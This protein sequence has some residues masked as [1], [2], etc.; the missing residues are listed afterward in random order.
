[1][2]TGSWLGNVSEVEVL[3]LD[4]RIVLEYVNKN[5][6]VALNSIYVA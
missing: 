4:V 5:F 1:M 3:E 2:C 6:G